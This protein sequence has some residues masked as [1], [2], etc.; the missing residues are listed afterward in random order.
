MV[1]L[2]SRVTA[3]TSRKSKNLFHYDVLMNIM[4]ELCGVMSGINDALK[5]L[6]LPFA[7]VFVVT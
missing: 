1:Q 2:E 6:L 4:R 3:A 7:F 5:L